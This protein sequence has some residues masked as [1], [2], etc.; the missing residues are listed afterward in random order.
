MARRKFEIWSV[1]IAEFYVPEPSQALLSW[2]RATRA[3]CPSVW[4]RATRAC[5]CATR[6]CHAHMPVRFAQVFARLRISTVPHNLQLYLSC[7]FCT[8]HVQPYSLLV[9]ILCYARS[10]IDYTH[11]STEK[12]LVPSAKFEENSKTAPKIGIFSNKA[13]HETHQKSVLPHAPK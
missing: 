12:T 2:R 9:S 8:V 5:R 4:R 1:D 10:S 3:I 6:T 13:H 7:I 11:L